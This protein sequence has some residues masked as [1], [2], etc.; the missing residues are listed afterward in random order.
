MFANRPDGPDPLEW[1]PVPRL[2]RTIPALPVR[3]V[4]AAVGYYAERFGFATL[5]EEARFAVI[6]RDDA[7]LHLWQADGRG[8]GAEA[9]LAGSASCR[10]EV[11]DV[12]GLH[13]E[14]RGKGVL[15]PKAG[16]LKDTDF[17]SREFATL[18]RDGNLIE[19]FRWR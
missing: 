7:R 8:P 3:E 1:P 2:G 9:H 12:D 5:H 14:L 13:E 4:A 19:F 10:I 11:D 15:H 6:E 18:D 16:H 17:G